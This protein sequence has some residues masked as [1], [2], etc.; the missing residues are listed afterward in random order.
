MQLWDALMGESAEVVLRFGV[1]GAKSLDITHSPIRYLLRFSA[2]MLKL[3]SIEQIERVPGVGL[4]PADDPSESIGSVRPVITVVVYAVA[5][6]GSHSEV[7][8][9]CTLSLSLCSAYVLCVALMCC[10]WKL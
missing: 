6:V 7:K 3:T 2:D 10:I 1:L 4:C 8:R 5:V 9:G